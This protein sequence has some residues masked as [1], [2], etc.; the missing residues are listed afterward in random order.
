[1]FNWHMIRD[2]FATEYTYDTAYN[3]RGAFLAAERA[4]VAEQRGFWGE[5]QTPGPE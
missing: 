4:A 5:C 3:H 2:G 1:M